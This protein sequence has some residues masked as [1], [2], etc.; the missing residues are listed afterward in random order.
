MGA[1]Y[2]EENQAA[3]RALFGASVPDDGLFKQ[4]HCGN[5]DDEKDEKPIF[6]ESL[7]VFL[8]EAVTLRFVTAFREIGVTRFLYI[9]D[10]Y[11]GS[12]VV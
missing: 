4:T 11:F 1:D 5:V 6:T 7:P 3:Q 8:S 9:A 2:S 12:S 10:T